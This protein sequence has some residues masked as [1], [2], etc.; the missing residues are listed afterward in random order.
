MKK[1]IYDMSKST[2]SM[3]RDENGCMCPLGAYLLACG[4]PEDGLTGICSPEE[5]ARGYHFGDLPEEAMWLLREV[6]GDE[7]GVLELVNTA[8][9]EHIIEAA[10]HLPDQ[11]AQMEIWEIFWAHGIDFEF[12]NFPAFMGAAP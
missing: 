1:L 3:L 2:D 6:E 5:M 10:A 9:A 4:V 11:E 12:D 7:L 8:D